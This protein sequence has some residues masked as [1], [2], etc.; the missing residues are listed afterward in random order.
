MENA[1]NGLKCAFENGRNMNSFV[2]SIFTRANV[3]ILHTVKW[4]NFV[5]VCSKWGK[6]F[7]GLIIVESRNVDAVSIRSSSWHKATKK[8]VYLILNYNFCYNLKFNGNHIWLVDH[9]A[10][11]L[12]FVLSF[13]FFVQQYKLVCTCSTPTLTFISCGQF[14][15]HFKVLRKARNF[16]FWL[17]D[18]SFH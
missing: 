10:K 5:N 3:R 13:C 9:T 4:R 6:N 2:C 16:K 12:D 15:P 18:F 7:Y 8:S 17:W 11:H 1:K 14:F